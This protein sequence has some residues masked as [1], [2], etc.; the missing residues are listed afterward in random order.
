MNEL[1]VRECELAK[2]THFIP[3]QSPLLCTL[4]P[5]PLTLSLPH[6]M[7][8]PSFSIDTSCKQGLQLNL[9]FPSDS[10]FFWFT[11]ANCR[12]FQL[13]CNKV[14]HLHPISGFPVGMQ[15]F[16]CAVSATWLCPQLTTHLAQ[17]W[18]C[19]LILHQ[20]CRNSFQADTNAV[21][22]SPFC[23]GY[24]L[25]LLSA[26][27][28]T[29]VATELQELAVWVFFSGKQEKERECT[30]VFRAQKRVRGFPGELKITWS[31]VCLTWNGLNVALQ[32]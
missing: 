14:L 16:L 28:L 10:V 22:Q 18:A 6:S 9:A 7:S 24:T 8:V 17:R 21:L 32:K 26:G 3:H 29:T 30:F 1:Q 13:Q 20:L 31:Y 4:S 25:G 11:E 2:L 5:T 23:S 27:S 15:A 12:G 19:P